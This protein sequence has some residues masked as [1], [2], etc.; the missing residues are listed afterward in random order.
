M[1]ENQPITM[2]TKS[3]TG[4]LDKERN[5]LTQMETDLNDVT[6]QINKLQAQVQHDVETGTDDADARGRN[7]QLSE[8]KR[9]RKKLDKDFQDQSALVA[10]LA[11]SESEEDIFHDTMHEY[12]DED[13]KEKIKETFLR[14]SERFKG[15]SGTWDDEAV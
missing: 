15:P 6:S 2:T 12:H 14:T 1:E 8:L 4:R 9:R 3:N 10:R 5:T 7:T 13:R 11:E